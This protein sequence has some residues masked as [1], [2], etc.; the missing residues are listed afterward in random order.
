MKNK[1]RQ[2]YTQKL[3][4]SSSRCIRHSHITG[5]TLIELL[6]VVSI[7]ALLSTIVFTALSDARIKAR[8]TAKNNLVM[9]YIKAL[10]LYRSE[11]PNDSY[12]I[13]NVT[14]FLGNQIPIC[15]GFDSNESCW[16]GGHPGSD[17][18]RDS[19]ASY[20]SGDFAHRGSV[21]IGPDDFN[22]VLYFC[23]AIGGVCPQYYLIWLL[24]KQV[25]TCVSGATINPYFSESNTHC[26]YPESS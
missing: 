18:V 14:N 5:F 25:S 6:V 7:I 13:T 17:S 10:E 15:L 24:E 4:T 20:F 26:T 8:N 19:L 21:L 9:E 2:L 11:N 16:T 23:P 12:P 22:G 1:K 3:K